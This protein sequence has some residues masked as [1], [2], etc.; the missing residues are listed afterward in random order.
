[1]KT[2]DNTIADWDSFLHSC[3]LE[4]MVSSKS[5]FYDDAKILHG[6]SCHYCNR[7]DTGRRKFNGGKKD[8]LNWIDDNPTEYANGSSHSHGCLELWRM[9]YQI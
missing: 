2:T 5:P 1:M 4:R 6:N 7:T 8:E 9:Q 3:W